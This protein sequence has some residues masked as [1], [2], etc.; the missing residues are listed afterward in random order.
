LRDINRIPTI[1]KELE[2]LWIK[3]PDLRLGQLILNVVNLDSKLYYMEDFELIAKLKLF[4]DNI[5]KI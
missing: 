4:Y 1:C 3:H 2:D 5:D